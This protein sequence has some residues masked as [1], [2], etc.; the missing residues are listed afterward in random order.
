[1]ELG[2]GASM[3]EARISSDASRIAIYVIPMDEELYIARCAL[4]L[5]T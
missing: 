2:G 5:L 1:M 4:R 3:E